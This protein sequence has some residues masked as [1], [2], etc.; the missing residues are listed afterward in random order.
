MCIKVK[1]YEKH[2][3]KQSAYKIMNNHNLNKISDMRQIKI[4]LILNE[5]KSILNFK[6]YDPNQDDFFFE[7]QKLS[8]LFIFFF[9]LRRAET[10]HFW[11]EM[12]VSQPF[13]PKNA[14]KHSKELKNLGEKKILKSIKTTAALKL[15]TQNTLTTTK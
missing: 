13:A 3:S 14:H 12:S 9:L 10:I 2:F 6:F 1:I 4:F 5:V 8:R 7:V 15:D 11:Y